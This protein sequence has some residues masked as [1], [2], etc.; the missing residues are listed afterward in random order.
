V[1]ATTT[2]KARAFKPGM[3]E[4]AVATGAYAV[5]AAGTTAT[6]AIVPAGG[7]FTT[8]QTVTI[9][10]P[11]GATLRYT[12]TGVDPT[13]S[14]ALVPGGGQV[15][16]DRAQVLKVR[17]WA[18]GVDPSAVRR[19]DFVI[20]GALAAGDNHTLALKEDGTVWA[21]GANNLGQVGNGTMTHQSSPV[22]VLTGVVA[23]AAG[24]EHS[25]AVKADGSVW[26]WG[27]NTNSQLGDGTTFTRLSPVQ[28]TGITTAV[29][30]AAG[31]NHTLVLMADRTV[32][33]MG[34]NSLG[35]IGD[36][37]TTQRTTAVPVLG[38]SGATT[39]AAGTDVSAAIVSDAAGAGWVATWGKNTV[40]QLG[41]GSLLTRLSPLLVAL[42]A[43]AT[44][45]AAGGD[46]LVALRADGQ[47]A[48]WGG[49]AFGQLGIGNTT[50]SAT[51]TLIGAPNALRHVAVGPRA[52]AG[53]RRR[54]AGVGVGQQRH[55]AS[56]RRQLARLRHRGG[57]EPVRHGVSGRDRTRR[58]RRAQRGE[59]A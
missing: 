33:A 54:G 59:R 8:R 48:T 13:T 37:T 19:A 39:I 35:Q 22:Q 47:L 42:G 1:A 14:D 46:M 3:T 27:R 32:W 4:S 34:A 17:A 31:S 30:V 36:G 55:G 6:P 44:G 41:D 18:A 25:L 9:T 5:D 24:G 49:N 51:P 50:A 43:P 23:I 16:V 45:L 11:A 52:H 56:R 20:T 10:G 28:S 15:V 57:D 12:T 7:L 2:V 26:G 53:A 38:L 58:W 21:W 29:Q 40:G